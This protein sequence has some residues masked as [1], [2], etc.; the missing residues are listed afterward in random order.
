[1]T[2]SEIIRAKSDLLF[3]WTFGY[4][5]REQFE[6]EFRALDD[7]QPCAWGDSWPRVVLGAALIL[8]ASIGWAWMLK[9]V[10]AP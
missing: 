8:A 2:I 1:M 4:V 3:R 6:R 5:D 9:T 10:L 7:R